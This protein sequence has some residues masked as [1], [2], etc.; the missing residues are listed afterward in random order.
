MLPKIIFLRY[1]IHMNP[2]I[3]LKPVFKEMIW[4]GCRLGTEFGYDIPSAHTGECWGIAAHP[5]GDAAI[6][7]AAYAGMTL[8]ELWR[9]K[10]ELFGNLGGDRFPLLVKIIDAKA[11]LSLQ[12]HP[13]DAYAAEH[14]HGSL[15]KTECWYIIDCPAHARLVV[16]HNART[17]EE[18]TDMIRKGD[19]KDL[20]RYLP[21]RKGDFIPIKPGT[22][23][24]ITSGCMILE[25]QQNSDITYRVYDYDRLVNGKP[26]DLHIKKS[27]DVIT[28]PAKSVEDS[29]ENTN[30]LP[31]NRWNQLIAGDYFKVYKLVLDGELE[32]LQE[33]PFLNM[34]VL[35][36][37]GCIDG[38]VIQKGD[39][40][41]L[42]SGYGKVKLNGRM[43][44]I[45]SAV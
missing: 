20:I 17:R 33:H 2:I 38:Q 4:G 11:D 40:F 7:N 45:A 18:L 10:P 3:F 39:H 30:D 42:P 23:H 9:Q 34:S 1:D 24:A 28:V 44:I 5:N 15:G 21:I 26:R 6:A 32:F 16:G 41:I 13:G 25:T 31:K 29:V 19:W 14:E 35:D 8:S 36:G 12:V 37:Q 43:E 27:I 22:V